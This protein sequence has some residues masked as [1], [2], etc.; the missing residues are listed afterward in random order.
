MF[1]ANPTASP[2]SNNQ[3]I[4]IVGGGFGGMRVARLLS[5]QRR[6]LKRPILLIDKHRHHVYT[7]LL[8]EV[9]SGCTTGVEAETRLIRGAAFRFEDALK[10]CCDVAF[11]RGEAAALDPAARTLRLKDG[12]SLAYHTLVLALGSETEFF[13]IPGLREHALTLKTRQDAL[14]I[15]RRVEMLLTKSQ[16]SRKN[17]ALR[18]VVG[19][20]GA[21]GTEF[22]AEMSGCFHAMERRGALRRGS[23]E[24]TLVEATGRLLGML[25]P[26]L[27]SFAKHRLEKRGV[28]VMLDTC[29]KTIENGTVMIAPRP[30]KPENPGRAR[31]RS[32]PGIGT[33]SVRGPRGLDRRSA[34]SE[35]I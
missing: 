11:M 18:L 10:S 29:F 22:A 5:R 34:G 20:G 25:K 4:I 26:E 19:G 33:A 6:C 27:S 24:I 7:P 16:G 30:L 12:T 23:W 15:R 13:G 3:P 1:P 28:K 2:R 9:A 21:T 14:D 35:R 31:V 8:Y 17:G 32:R